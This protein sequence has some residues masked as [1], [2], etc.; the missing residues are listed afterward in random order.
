[1]NDFD[2]TPLIKIQDTKEFQLVVI[3]NDRHAASRLFPS[4]HEKLQRFKNIAS[5]SRFSDLLKIYVAN[6]DKKVVVFVDVTSKEPLLELKEMIYGAHA[7]KR[8]LLF[9]FT[10]G[11]F[12]ESDFERLIV[13][14]FDDVFELQN[15][16]SRKF[17]RI[18]SWVRRFGGTPISEEN[19]E[20]DA[21]TFLAQKSAKRIGKWTIISSE[22][23]ARDD[24]GQKVGLTRQE[25]DFLTLLF[26]SPELV[27]NAAYE[28][29]FKAPHAIVHKLKKKLG[30]DLPVEHDSGGRYY[31]VT[32]NGMS[33]GTKSA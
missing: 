5:I 9:A 11:E 3:S 16:D 20:R 15:D 30:G 12:T 33:P 18:Y 25:V 13:A 10:F 23:V 24:R 17:L 19:A 26:D 22:K 27:R 32:K 6:K 28:R 1:M 29:F 21:I 31:L 4:N 14:G 2:A 7:E 8:G